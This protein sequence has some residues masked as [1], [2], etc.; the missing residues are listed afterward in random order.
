MII[1]KSPQP[2]FKKLAG[3]VVFSAIFSFQ[4]PSLLIAQ[5]SAPAAEAPATPTLDETRI[6]MDKWIETQQ[7][8]SK[9]RKDWQ[10]GKE[11]LTGRVNLVKGEIELLQEKIKAA[12]TAI[13]ETETKRSEFVAQIDQL[14]ATDAAMADKLTAM[15]DEIRKLMVQLPFPISEKLQ[16]LYQRI[17]AD[18][19]K[20]RI[21]VAERLQNVLGIL[22]EVNKSNNEIFV[23]FEVHT[24]A[25]G[26]PAEV[27]VIYVGLAQG[28]YISA[29]GEA[30]IGRPTPEGW[31][32]EATPESAEAIMSALEIMQGKKSPAF[33]PLPVTIQ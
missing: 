13:T 33:M 4:V 32:W 11:I 16:P 7:I 12:D 19:A 5:A 6:V 20:A 2:A 21:S 1:Q 27:Q 30:G 14:K 3:F 18:P 29:K 8:I 24:L 28:Y 9:E 26:K 17:P 25:D 15:E 10:Q 22:N 31:K 23:N